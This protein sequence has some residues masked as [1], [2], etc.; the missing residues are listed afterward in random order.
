MVTID[1]QVHAYE[2][3]RPGRP[4][5]AV[6]HGPA[7][8]TGDDMVKAMDSV[9]VDGALLVSPYTMYRYDASY[10]L[11]VRAAHPDRFAVIKPVDPNDPQVADTI[12]QWA[13]TEGTVAIRIMMTQGVST[14]AA[15]PGIG[16]VLAAAAR[17]SFPVNLLCWGRLDQVGQMAARHPETR[18]VIDHL[19]LQ[20][21]FEPPAPAQPWAELPKLLGLA[22]HDNIV[23]KISGAC[24]LSHQPF[25]YKDIWDPLGRI[26]D[27]FGFD[28]CMWGT[29]WTR[30][31]GLLTYKQGV[32]AFRVT[33]RL[34]DSDR[35]ALMGQTLQKVYDWAPAKAGSA[36]G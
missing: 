21:P 35:A 31:V 5:A 14:D 15:D 11:D 6:L 36:S 2:R 18:L 24:T 17:H 29:D 26:F 25:P 10:A 19:G 4:W 1:V 13:D 32:E 30:A 27:A 12:A 28:R 20:Q 16:R 3:D 22:A 33:D 9:G 34:S 7:E 8:V 23:V